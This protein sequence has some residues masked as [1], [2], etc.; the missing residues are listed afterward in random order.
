LLVVGAGLVIVAVV[1]WRAPIVGQLLSQSSLP[2]SA[3]SG[4]VSD[5]WLTGTSGTLKDLSY[6]SVLGPPH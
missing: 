2:P 1:H 4:R 5:P 6:P 3:G